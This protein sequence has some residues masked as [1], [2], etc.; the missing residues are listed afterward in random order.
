VSGTGARDH[1]RTMEP[2]LTDTHKFRLA[3]LIRQRNTYREQRDLLA[4]A[5]GDHRAR[6]VDEANEADSELWSAYMSVMRQQPD[7]SIRRAGP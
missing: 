3:R 4:S 7:L 1:D 5:I 2:I 6:H